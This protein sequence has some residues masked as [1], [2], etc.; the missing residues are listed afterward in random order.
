MAVG[1]FG[2]TGGLGLFFG[3]KP[4]IAGIE[5]EKNIGIVTTTGVEIGFLAL[6]NITFDVA[7]GILRILFLKTKRAEN[8]EF[9]AFYF[10]KCGFEILGFDRG[11]G[12]EPGPAG[13]DNLLIN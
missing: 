10:V 12:G 7:F 11:G 3:A 4:L 1:G 9:L 2:E 5:L 8:A 6:A 13:G